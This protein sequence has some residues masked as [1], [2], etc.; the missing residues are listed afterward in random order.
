MQTSR[1]ILA[2]EPRLLRGMLRRA[3]A[4]VPGL[5]VVGEV[6]D[7]AELSS[8]IGQSEAQWVIV[9]IWS[10]GTVP[11]ALKSVLARRSALCILGLA[12]DGSQAKVVCPG[13]NEDTRT[14]LSLDELIAI[15]RKR[16]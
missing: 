6:T 11:S 10:E 4:G 16:R 12:A 15:L 1:V 3:I 2:N 8:L 5:E 7:P 9:S 14:R 13:S